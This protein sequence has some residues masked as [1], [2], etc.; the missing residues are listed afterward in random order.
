MSSLVEQILGQSAPAGQPTVSEPAP[1]LSLDEMAEDA[2]ARDV[3]T[4]LDAKDA[5][6]FRRALRAFLNVS[7]RE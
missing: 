6:Q 7:P 4:A 5:K 3:L 1:E 2:A